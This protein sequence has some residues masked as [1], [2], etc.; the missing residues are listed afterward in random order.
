MKINL[1]HLNFNVKKNYQLVYTQKMIEIVADL[2]AKDLEV[3][4]YKF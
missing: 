1:E 3:F 4:N 2:Y